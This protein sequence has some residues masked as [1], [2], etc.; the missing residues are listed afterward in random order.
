MAR[1]A[2]HSADT[3]PFASVKQATSALRRLAQSNWPLVTP[4]SAMVDKITAW[5][6]QSDHLA[7][8]VPQLVAAASVKRDP[9]IRV[10]AP[11][12][13]LASTETTFRA[14]QVFW[15]ALFARGL[16]P[17]IYLPDAQVSPLGLVAYRKDAA[18]LAFLLKHTTPPHSRLVLNAEHLKGDPNKS[19]M[20]GSTLLHRLLERN[21]SNQGG[22]KA[23]AACVALMIA[24]DPDAPLC[25]TQ[26]GRYPDGG[27]PKDW[28]L[29]Q[30]VCSARQAR[31]AALEHAAITAA[32]DT[33]TQAA[34]VPFRM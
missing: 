11:L 17:H 27:L 4:Q 31:Q 28:A 22:E 29:R 10:S 6:A 13:W 21:A 19:K 8:S 3:T 14:G 30:V 20:I 5:V 12:E 25:T 23:L 2:P 26:K 7:W 16:A 15:T 34:G 33:T 18:A 32:V 1:T 9:D 24:H